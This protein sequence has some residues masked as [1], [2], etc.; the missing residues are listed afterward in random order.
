MK[1]LPYVEPIVSLIAAHVQGHGIYTDAIAHQFATWHPE[2]ST[3][4]IRE[5]VAAEGLRRG[6]A[7][8]S[9]EMTLLA[10]QAISNGTASETIFQWRLAGNHWGIGPLNQVTHPIT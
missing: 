4:K 8:T 5:R 9:H 6:T 3:H 10:S 1:R 2:L 7:G